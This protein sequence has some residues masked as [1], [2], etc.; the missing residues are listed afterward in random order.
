MNRYRN[1][2]IINEQWDSFINYG[3]LNNIICLIIIFIFVKKI[4]WDCLVIVFG[5]VFKKL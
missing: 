4:R 2:L 5:I 3:G 1:V